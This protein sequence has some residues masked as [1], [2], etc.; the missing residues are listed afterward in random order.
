MYMYMKYKYTEFNVYN[1]KHV[2][3]HVGQIETRELQ[4]L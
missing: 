2:A 1:H 4:F 3:L